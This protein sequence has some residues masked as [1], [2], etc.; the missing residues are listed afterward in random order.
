MRWIRFLILCVLLPITAYAADEVSWDGNT[1][2][3]DNVEDLLDT[4]DLSAGGYTITLSGDVLETDP[5][6]W[7]ADD[8]GVVGRPNVLDLNG[9]TWRMT[10]NGL[11]LDVTA[12]ADYIT[13]QGPGTIRNESEDS[14]AIRVYTAN[15]TIKDLTL[16]WGADQVY[17]AGIAFVDGSSAGLV[18]SVF[19]YS[20]NAGQ[21]NLV[22]VYQ[23]SSGV[24]VQNCVGVAPMFRGVV[25]NDDDGVDTP[26][27][28]VISNNS[29]YGYDSSG[30]YINS[31]ATASEVTIKNN[32][33]YGDGSCVGI[34]NDDAGSA[35]TEDYN[36]FHNNTTNFDNAAGANDIGTNSQTGDPRFIN[37]GGTSHLDYWPLNPALWRAGTNIATVTTDYYGISRRTVPTIGAV[38]MN[39]VRLDVRRGED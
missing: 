19:G 28:I 24:T 11:I 8:T 13:V 39:M 31:N 25:V 14:H 3:Y 15:F 17:R 7:A 34:D 37:P 36:Q 22:N 23:N 6:T 10:A 33:F 32:I 12:G 16:I 4:E 26:S 30:V 35:P 18:D 1:N 27:D 21:G 2:T 9:Y 38:Q 29:F 5:C 20:L